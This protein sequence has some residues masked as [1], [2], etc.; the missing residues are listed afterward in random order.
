MRN[1][2]SL[3]S[4]ALAQVEVL[5]ENEL[6]GITRLRGFRAHCS[7]RFCCFVRRLSDFLDLDAGKYPYVS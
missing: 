7:K 1:R 3:G 2:W 5:N 6:P 4:F